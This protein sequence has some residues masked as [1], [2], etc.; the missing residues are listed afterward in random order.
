MKKTRSRLKSTTS[1]SQAVSEEQ[2]A[3]SN[4]GKSDA[5]E[6]AQESTVTEPEVQNKLDEVTEDES[7]ASED[8]STLTDEV[9][10][11]KTP[12]GRK[13]KASEMKATESDNEESQGVEKVVVKVEMDSESGDNDKSNER[14]ES[15]SE[16]TASGNLLV[17]ASLLMFCIF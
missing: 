13:R 1:E 7:V 12:H 6:A 9:V 15:R 11:E 4:G 2:M 5:G 14:D 10:I 17:T 8:T 3:N 16:D